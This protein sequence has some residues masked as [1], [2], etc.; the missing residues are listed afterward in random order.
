MSTPRATRDFAAELSHVRCWDAALQATYERLR[1]P[2]ADAVLQNRAE[3]V[4]L[5]EWIDANA[6]RTYLEI[7]VWTGRLVTTLHELFDFDLVASCDLGAARMF[8]LPIR[9]PFGCRHFEGSSHGPEFEAWRAALGPIDLVMIDGDHSLEGVRRDFEMQRRHPHRFLGF[10]DI[11]GDNDPQ[12][13]GVAALW[14]ELD[15]DKYE[16]VA[17]NPDLPTEP[18]GG[19]GMG[20]GLWRAH[21]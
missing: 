16:I 14:R 10:H 12:S 20:I 18:D 3:L 15:G 1:V 11:R 2:L 5:C 8:G 19:Y 7:G 9:L 13:A 6:V 4:A 21:P 17:P